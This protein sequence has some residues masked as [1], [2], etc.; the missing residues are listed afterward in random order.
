MSLRGLRRRIELRESQ[1]LRLWNSELRNEMRVRSIGVLSSM[2]VAGA[3]TKAVINKYRHRMPFK[4]SMAQ[5][6]A[7]DATDDTIVR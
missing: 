2:G 1:V 5:G 6:P 4:P 3:I 7:R